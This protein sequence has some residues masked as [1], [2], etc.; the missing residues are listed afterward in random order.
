MNVGLPNIS[1]SFSATENSVRK[2]LETVCTS[3][4]QHDLPP[5]S[6]GVVE[7]VL[8]EICNNIV[9]HAYAESD[10]GNINLTIWSDHDGVALEIRDSGRPMPGLALPE[11]READLASALADL[12]E[13][14]FGWGL[15]RD[16]TH[17][18]T[19]ERDGSRNI[20][21][22]TIATEQPLDLH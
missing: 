2:A 3:L 8:A 17:S 13:G 5:V 12:P 4:R 14:G 11:K 9:E 22:C 6:N 16:L 10:V 19:Y 20:V 1:L 15:I 7:L 18:L 21:K